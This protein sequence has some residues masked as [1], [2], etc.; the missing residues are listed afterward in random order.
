MVWYVDTAKPVRKRPT[1]V[2]DPLRLR[3]LDEWVALG[4]EA[5]QLSCNAVNLD[6]V[7]SVN[8]LARRLFDF[9]AVLPPPT[10]DVLALPPASPP[11]AELLVSPGRTSATGISSS[12]AVCST[13]APVI[14][15]NPSSPPSL[16][17]LLDSG[18]RPVWDLDDRD[19]GFGIARSASQP[20]FPVRIDVTSADN[21]STTSSSGGLGTR[22]RT[23]RATNSRHLRP[24]SSFTSVAGRGRSGSLVSSGARLRSSTVTTSSASGSVL[25]ARDELASLVRQTVVDALR[26]LGHVAGGVGLGGVVSGTQSGASTVTSSV[27]CMLGSGGVAGCLGVGGVGSGLVGSSVGVG[28]SG[29]WPGAGLG[30]AAQ[31]Q[32]ALGG[33]PPAVSTGSLPVGGPFGAVGALGVPASVAGARL[34]PLGSQ[35]LPSAQAQSHALAGGLL[36]QVPQVPQVPL[37]A[38]G[39]SGQLGGPG[40]FAAQGAQVGVGG[41]P[42]DPNAELARYDL[43]AVASV[44]PRFLHQI[45][46]GE[47]VNF[48]QLFSA[49][50]LGFSSRPEFTMSLTHDD[51][52]GLDG[53]PTFAIRP[54]QQGGAR[55]SS[56]TDWSRAWC[57]FYTA[58]T[59]FRPHLSSSMLRYQSIIA[60]FASTYPHAAWAAYD[61]AFRQ[62]VANN[63]AIGW[64]SIHDELFDRHLRSAVILPPRSRVFS[65]VSTRPFTSVARGGGLISAQ[66]AQVVC[67]VCA[68]PGHF[69]RSCPNR[70]HASTVTPPSASQSLA[71]VRASASPRPPVSSTST[72]SPLIAPGMPAFRAPQRQRQTWCFAFNEAR[73]CLPNCR[74]PHVCSRCFESH[75]VYACDK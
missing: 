49:I 37:G 46:R 72:P 17:D 29:V 71:L 38:Q 1:P 74:W 36:P 51:T 40:A 11:N 43:Q 3:S 28:G 6:P 8:Q 73:P 42:Q 58:S 5:L 48:D 47:Y 7:G 13:G 20:T 34:W 9:Y 59:V 45:R 70:P 50:T 27:N 67:F 61:S 2:T 39:G 60:R 35:G 44:P 57:D 23:S 33:V 19:V 69:A 18:S 16:I 64:G 55:I 15:L 10:D 62:A 54:R 56:Y 32:T 52:L 25:V 31:A 65:T 75:P 63:P 14:D 30:V 68:R 4:R 66:R 24:T 41:V 53:C 12:S 22:L 26:G 21:T